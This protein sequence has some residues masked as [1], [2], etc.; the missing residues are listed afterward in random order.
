MYF[1]FLGF[2]TTALTIPTLLGLIQIWFSGPDS[3]LPAVF[4]ILNSFWVILFLVVSFVR[5]IFKSQQYCTRVLADVETAQQL[6]GV[7]V[8]HDQNDWA[9]RAQGEFQ[10]C[11]GS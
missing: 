5:A 3:I 4:T 7:L 8:E 1:S 10:G 6:P 9:G 11:H 2:Y